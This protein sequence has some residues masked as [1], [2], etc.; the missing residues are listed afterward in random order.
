MQRKRWRELR[1]VDSK[2]QA[3]GDSATQSLP[4]FM[5]V[6]SAERRKD[7]F[8]VDRVIALSD[9]AAARAT[10]LAHS[11]IVWRKTSALHR[12]VIRV[13]KLLKQALDDLGHW[14]DSV[15]LT[16]SLADINSAEGTLVSAHAGY[17]PA[18]QSIEALLKAAVDQSAKTNGWEEL[19]RLATAPKALFNALGSRASMTRRSRASIKRYDRSMSGTER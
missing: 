5:Q 3:L 1:S 16:A 7:G 19:E 17:G 10:W 8:R 6:T 12:A 14:N 4:E 11:R 18:A 9:D 2:I 13:R 15:G